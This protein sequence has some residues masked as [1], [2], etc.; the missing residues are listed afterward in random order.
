MVLE[1]SDS[2]WMV[3]KA[4]LN[5]LVS[6]ITT[7]FSV[8]LGS[9]QTM[10]KFMFNT[11]R[12]FPIPA[13][14]K[15]RKFLFQIIFFT[16]LYYLLQSSQD[17]YA[18]IA[19]NI[20]SGWGSKLADALEDSVSSVLVATMKLS[21][22]HGLFTWLTHNIFGAHVVYLPAILASILA[23]APFLET[24]WCC[25]PAFLDLWL[26][27]DRFYLG[28]LLVLIHFIVPSN[29]NPIIHS[30]IKGGGHPY[31]T[32]LS[33]VGAMYL[34]G[35]EGAIL[36]PLLLCLL[37]VLGTVTVNSLN[38]SPTTFTHQSSVEEPS[39]IASPAT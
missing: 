24:Y 32:A 28:L 37:V 34:F 2:I 14:F 19:M 4:N 20:N 8:V 12:S 29:F 31:L 17:R 16:T 33:I 39:S 15:F 7:L 38:S 1:V 23:A 5:L 11:V 27:Q 26:S 9:S 13:T 18:P 36:G 6:A 22:F 25:L 30:E 10:I 21:L 3:L 35:I